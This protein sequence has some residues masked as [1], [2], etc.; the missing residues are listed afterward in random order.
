MN[1]NDLS[2][3]NTITSTKKQLE[4]LLTEEYITL[5]NDFED[6]DLKLIFS[7]LHKQIIKCFKSM[8]SRLPATENSNR[9]Y[10]ADDSRALLQVLKISKK[11]QEELKNTIYAFK[12]DEDYEELFDICIDFLKESFGSKIP[13]G[14]DTITIYYEIPIFIRVS[15]KVIR[16]DNLNFELKLI[17]NGSYAHV[18]K[19]KDDY[20][21]KF[22]AIKR[23][24]EDLTDKELKRF[25]REFE[26]MKE[27]KSPY[28]LEVYYFKK[29]TNEYC[30]EYADLTLQK[31]ID[32]KNNKLKIEERKSIGLQIIR[33]FK[34]IWNKGFLHR[35][36]SPNNILLKKYH[37]VVVVKISDF[38][39]VKIPESDLTKHET[40]L[41]GSFNDFSDLSQIGFEN[42][43][44]VHEIYALTRI[45]FFVA[46]RKT[47][48]EN[49]KC[50]FLEKGTNGD[51]NKR[52]KTLE[53]LE[54]DFSG[55]LENLEN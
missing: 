31:Y 23:A 29:D 39:L 15:N 22:F 53:E 34:Y 24:K 47:R 21:N 48:I 32:K 19:Y 3:R 55:F 26:I 45:L 30:M 35:D 12:I 27:L 37:D 13:I 9:Y 10:W 20:Y 7:T 18:F 36:I 52:Y 25:Q 44:K 16:N 51:K 17:G 28:I 54:K 49:Q 43:D 1:K 46:T 8:N 33:A 42:Y 50:D 41:K 14:L 4:N 2:I 11:F 5:Y 40:E 6:C 38:G